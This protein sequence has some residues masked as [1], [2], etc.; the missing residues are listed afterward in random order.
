MLLDEVNRIK[1]LINEQKNV[2]GKASEKLW[3]QVKKTFAKGS[4][5]TYEEYI[6]NSLKKIESLLGK[7]G[8][9]YLKHV[10]STLRRNA[11]D[12]EREI[13]ELIGKNN[14]IKEKIL[15]ELENNHTQEYEKLINSFIDD[16]KEFMD[17][18]F[19]FSLE[20]S[21]GNVNIA[22][23]R[24]SSVLKDE[25]DDDVINMYLKKYEPIEYGYNKWKIIEKKGLLNKNKEISDGV[26][27]SIKNGIADGL[28]YPSFI[29]ILFNLNKKIGPEQ[30]EGWNYFMRYILTQ[31][32]VKLDVKKSAQI[33]LKTGFS[34]EFSYQIA[35]TVGK[36]GGNAFYR[37]LILTAV[38]TILN[39]LRQYYKE[40]GE[41]EYEKRKNINVA[42]LAFKEVPN[43]WINQFTWFV[44]FG[45]TANLIEDILKRVPTKK[46]IEH[47][48]L[49][50]PIEE[51]IEY[52]S[53]TNTIK[54]IV[55]NVDSTSLT[56]ND[57][58]EKILDTEIGF[59]AFCKNH[60][61]EPLV[62]KS[63]PDEYGLYYTTDGKT[64]A[65]FP[66]LNSF[67]EY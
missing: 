18:V 20:K 54:D 49:G 42:L 12:A 40:Q 24:F 57:A 59:K 39:G 5:K 26:I 34:K 36:I 9:E 1:S 2:V 45:K 62:Y 51:E 41:T 10:Y 43:V 58:I 23:E 30:I 15:K 64:W 22:K 4:E 31:T 35:Y 19:I 66:E 6:T 25:I 8:E 32:P 16:T 7:D 33:L 28:D 48:V 67:D 52:K 13:I 61:P 46:L 21:N 60:K 63:G 27:K 44:P 37:Y 14:L 47:I 56:Q 53:Q 50:T 11:A 38:C 17:N 55:S 3:N 29:K 65:F